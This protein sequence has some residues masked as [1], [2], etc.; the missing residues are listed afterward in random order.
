MWMC[1]VGVD[2]CVTS[3]EG[4]EYSGPCQEAESQADVEN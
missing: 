2:W 4:D 3:R 1:D